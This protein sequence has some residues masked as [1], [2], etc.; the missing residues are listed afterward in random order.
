MIHL[1]RVADGRKIKTI[2]SSSV[3]AKALAFSVDGFR[4]AT[5]MADT[6]ILV[7]ELSSNP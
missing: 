3:F 7:W 6:S 2:R 4:L 5:G 1:Y